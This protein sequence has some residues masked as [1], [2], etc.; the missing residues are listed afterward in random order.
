[1]ILRILGE[2]AG[3]LGV[4]HLVLLDPFP[5]T[6]CFS[7]CSR[8]PIVLRVCFLTLTPAK[9]N[10]GWLYPTLFVIMTDYFISLGLGGK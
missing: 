7:T 3:R 5:L 1:M 8:Q 4:L 10:S 9:Y 2:A 6:V